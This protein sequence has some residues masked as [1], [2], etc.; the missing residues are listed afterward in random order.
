MINLFIAIIIN[1]LDE[2]KKERLRELEGPVSREELLYGRSGPPSPRSSGW[3]NG[4]TTSLTAKAN[5]LGE[6]VATCQRYWV[7]APD[8][9][10][11]GLEP[12]AYPIDGCGPQSVGG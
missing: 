12:L 8:A 1:N 10:G 6:E 9:D 11:A 2:A 5:F 3:N 4:W 7:A